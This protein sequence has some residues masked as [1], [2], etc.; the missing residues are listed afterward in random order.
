MSR[1]MAAGV[2][3]GFISIYVLI[4]GMKDTR[5]VREKY[6]LLM[7]TICK[8]LHSIPLKVKGKVVGPW[9]G[10]FIIAA[11]KSSALL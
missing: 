11:N 9:L 3:I 5:K 4:A 8:S 10:S 7:L 1:G 2:L 6:D